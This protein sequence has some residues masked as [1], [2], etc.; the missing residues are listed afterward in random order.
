MAFGRRSKC[1]TWGVGFYHPLKT[2][3]QD[4][5]QRL[6]SMVFP[7]ATDLRGAAGQKNEQNPSNSSGSP[8]S[9]MPTEPAPSPAQVHFASPAET[10]P[11]KGNQSSLRL[12]DEALTQCLPPLLSE[13]YLGTV[14]F[15]SRGQRRENAK[16][17]GA[18]ND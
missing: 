17:T 14:F 18:L 6:T 16:I 13:L 1:Y 11:S 3:L 7:T 2:G 12:C 15:P 8:G 10:L 4:K 9:P 5:I